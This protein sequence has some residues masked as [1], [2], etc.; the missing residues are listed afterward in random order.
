LAALAQEFDFQAFERASR[1]WRR[2]SR[3]LAVNLL[4]TMRRR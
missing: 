2:W 3:W 4:K 1:G